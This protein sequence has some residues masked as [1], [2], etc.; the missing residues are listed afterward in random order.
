MNNLYEFT[1]KVLRGD[2]SEMPEGLSG[3][4]VACYAAA[5]DYQAA[6]KKGVQAVTQMG[7]KF[8]NL[9]NGVREI[10][11]TS[12]GDYFAKV[13]PDYVDQMPSAAQLPSVVGEGQVFFGPF[14]GFTS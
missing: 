3:A 13:W 11:I 14:V 5:P 2:C 8:D 1:M 4:Y 10:P 7:Y 9:L 12:W 6:V